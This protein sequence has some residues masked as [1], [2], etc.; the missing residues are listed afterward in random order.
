M[1]YRYNMLWVSSWLCYTLMLFCEV[2]GPTVECL[3]KPKLTQLLGVG[4]FLF[5]F[6]FGMGSHFSWLFVHELKTKS[7][8]SDLG[9][10][11]VV[12]YFL[13]EQE[14]LLGWRFTRTNVFLAGVCFLQEILIISS[15]VRILSRS[16]KLFRIITRMF[17]ETLF[18]NSN[19]SNLVLDCWK[20]ILLATKKGIEV[21]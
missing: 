14:T 12:R 18:P 16:F 4:N 11:F 9:I 21:L 19:T 20:W 6:S 8:L 3:W 2:S 5:L 7:Q 1:I 15:I 10:Q 17:F 13:A